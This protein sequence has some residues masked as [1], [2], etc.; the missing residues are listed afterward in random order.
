MVISGSAQLSRRAKTYVNQS[1]ERIGQ[2]PFIRDAIEEKLSKEQIKRWLMCA[3][4]ESWIFP[5]IVRNMLVRC[6]PKHKKI[7]E[8]LAQNLNDEL[9]NGNPQEAHFHHYIQLLTELGISKEEFLNYNE[10]AGIKL[11]LSLGQNVSL[12]ENAATA[13][14]YL[15]VNEGLTPV[16]YAAVGRALWQH[17]Q[18]AEIPFLEVHVAI[19]ARHVEG[20]Y[21]AVDQLT[22][23]D[24]DGLE[25][26]V[27][28]GERGMS[29]LLDEAY[30]VFEHSDTQTPEVTTGDLRH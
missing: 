22:E 24:W 13:I 18:F 28:L 9:G 29:I 6:S 12:Y 5:N 2:H 30:G 20:L 8:I 26:G 14:G 10:R 23:A 4:R 25:Y 1:L 3:G 19:D 11:A 7:A 16:T 27:S 17:Y 15:L 21:W